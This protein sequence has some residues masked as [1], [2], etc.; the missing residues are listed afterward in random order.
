MPDRITPAAQPAV[1]AAIADAF[2]GGTPVYPVGGGTSLG[3]GLPAAR[4]GVE[5]SLAKLNRLIDYPARDMTITV[6][7]GI[8]MSALAATL[9]AE[10]QRLPIDVPQ[11]DR[12]TLGGVIATNFSGPLRYGHRTIRDYV[13]GIN[14]VDGRGKP[15]KGGGRV[16]KNVAGY[17]FC[18]LL[19]GSLGT[20][21]VITQVTLKV[22]PIPEQ[23]ALF[24]C[25]VKDLAHAERLLT[26]LVASATTPVAIELVA[27]P[28]WRDDP[29]LEPL[30]SGEF[31]HL[32]VALE[33]TG[34]E[35]EWM[36][37]TLVE[38]LKAQG[39]T[40]NIVADD[41]AVGLWH[42]LREFPAAE[43]AL[44][45]KANV[46]PSRA[47]EMVR[48][49]TDAVADCSIQAHAGNGIVLA[50][51]PTFPAGG[52]SRIL[53]GRLQPAAQN[54]AG[55]LIVLSSTLS[56]ELTRQ[57]VWGTTAGAAMLMEAVKRQFDPKN[58]LNPGRFV[59][60]NA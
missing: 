51:Y 53:V 56:G 19:T 12:A 17:D 10:R 58:L 47:V 43:S 34:S 18:K 42:R 32:V 31:G 41:R 48:L 46:P 27:G 29:A 4:P 3:F 1:V 54:A 50:R 39:A 14:A 36:K 20:L 28:A 37:T 13:I 11:A 2:A 44:V 52:V 49:L 21:G 22:K 6:E 15:F 40:G 9:A 38:E 55:N 45:L 60:S 23:T 5:L 26:A 33:G 16:V 35:V 24:A 25:R 7:A 30:T 8:T 57:A 59:Y